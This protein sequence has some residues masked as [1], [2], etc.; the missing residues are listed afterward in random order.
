MTHTEYACTDNM[1]KFPVQAQLRNQNTV[2]RLLQTTISAQSLAQLCT[3]VTT[4][5]GS[6]FRSPFFAAVTDF[7]PPRA[8]EQLHICA[9]L[10]SLFFNNVY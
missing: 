8:L 2:Q 7:V 3:R 4:S 5:R 9:H 10:S 6:V 1:C